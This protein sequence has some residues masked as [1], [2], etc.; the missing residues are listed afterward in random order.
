MEIYKL[1]PP[2]LQN[3]VKYFVLEHPVAKIIQDEIDR[4]NCHL[5]FKFKEKA[6]GA[7]ICKVRG[8]DFFCNEY[9]V[10][11]NDEASSTTSDDDRFRSIFQ[12]S[13]TSSDD[14]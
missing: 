5:T 13:S 4:L 2:E 1:L 9:F 12:V 3:K 11:R 6:N 7:T 14:E 10:R 8:I